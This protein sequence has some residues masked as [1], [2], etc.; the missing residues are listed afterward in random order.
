MLLY[1]FVIMAASVGNGGLLFLLVRYKELQ[2]KSNILIGGLAVVDLLLIVTVPLNVFDDFFSD[3]HTICI[4][5]SGFTFIQMLATSLLLAAIALERYI[6]ILYPLHYHLWVTTVRVKI[7]IGVIVTYSAVMALVPQ[8]AGWNGYRYRADRNLTWTGANGC[9]MVRTVTA[10]F[11]GFIHIGH[12]YPSMIVMAVMYARIFY[13][14][15]KQNRQIQAQRSSSLPGD[16]RRPSSLLKER[17]GVIV[18][19]LLVLCYAVCWIPLT[20]LHLDAFDWFKRKILTEFRSPPILHYPL[21]ALALSNSI[22]NPCLYGFCNRDVRRTL[23]RHFMQYSCCYS[24][25][26]TQQPNIMFT[27]GGRNDVTTQNGNSTQNEYTAS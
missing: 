11:L 6:A 13:E 4:F 14:G 16:Y 8:L 2:N 26:P 9:H 22:I 15:H 27:V 17:R 24:K 20:I 12:F 21:T 23:R 5:S 18:L 7:L 3:S 10:G 1:F 25:T 19:A